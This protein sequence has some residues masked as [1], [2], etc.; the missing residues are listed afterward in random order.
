MNTI[1]AV[2]AASCLAVTAFT[3]AAALMKSRDGGQTVRESIIESWTN[4]SIGF[5]INYAANIAVLPLAGFHITAGDAFW[6]GCVF[7]AISV[8]R[9]FVIR[10]WF[11][12]RMG[13]R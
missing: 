4:I 5:G 6:V 3:I 9:S 10:R 2:G 7:T 11:N 8:V 12:H 13:G 1:T